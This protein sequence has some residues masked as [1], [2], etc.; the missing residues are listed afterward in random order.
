MTKSRELRALERAL[1]EASKREEKLTLAG[2][3]QALVKGVQKSSRQMKR[4][5][6]V[7]RVAVSGI[8]E[9][10]VSG[11]QEEDLDKCIALLAKEAAR[12]EQERTGQ[13]EG[14]AAFR[15]M[16]MSRTGGTTQG[17]PGNEN[18]EPNPPEAKDDS[19]FLPSEPP[20]QPEGDPET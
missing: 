1:E 5:V 17:T 3:N 2:A 11:G 6:K 14:G 7:C 9:Q 18:G 4:Q 13:Q 19:T 16:F 15:E 10:L 12:E 20:P 8:G